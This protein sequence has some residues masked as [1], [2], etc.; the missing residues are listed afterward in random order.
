V[1]ADPDRIK[2]VFINLLD[3]S[4][5]Y[6]PGSNVTVRLTPEDEIVKVE[7]SDNGPGIPA[8][9][10][11]YIFEPFRRG[12]QTA[13]RSKGTGLGLTIIRTILEQHQAP[14]SVKSEVGIG[15]TF[16]FSLA[17]SQSSRTKET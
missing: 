17:T 15:T 9:D 12:K 1:L 16:T 2:Q 4:I 7:I 10:L 3:N 14:I 13:A 6:A 5:K 11:P 8:E